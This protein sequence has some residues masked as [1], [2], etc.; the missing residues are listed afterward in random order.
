LRDEHILEL[1]PDAIPGTHR[2]SVG[3]YRLPDFDA[4]GEVEVDWLD[5]P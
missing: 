5:L 4:L 1:P 3:M 2:L